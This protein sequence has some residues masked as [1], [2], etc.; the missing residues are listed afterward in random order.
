MKHHIFPDETSASFAAESSLY[1]QAKLFQASIG[2]ECEN[3]TSARVRRLAL[4]LMT[5]SVDV[6]YGDL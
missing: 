3:A 4:P 1:G 6:V 2:A 5:S